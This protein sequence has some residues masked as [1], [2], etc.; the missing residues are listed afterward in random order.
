VT[1][2]EVTVGRW[3]AEQALQTARRYRSPFDLQRAKK[4][5]AALDTH[6]GVAKHQRLEVVKHVEGLG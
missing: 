4:V 6:K 5:M 2:G 3:V 1:S